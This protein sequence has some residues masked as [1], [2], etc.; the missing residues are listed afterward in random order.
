MNPSIDDKYVRVSS[1]FE[2]CYQNINIF[3]LKFGNGMFTFFAK[4]IS[5]ATTLSTPFD[6]SNTFNDSPYFQ[7]SIT[8]RSCVY[9]TIA[10]S[11]AHEANETFV[12]LW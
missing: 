11:P 4:Y 3:K 8:L 9:F 10:N 6:Q 2:T 1:Y 5:I 12:I 7:R